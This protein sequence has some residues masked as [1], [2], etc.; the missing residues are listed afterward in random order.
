MYS[1]VPNSTY[2]IFKLLSAC[3]YEHHTQ[4]SVL[5]CVEVFYY[6]LCSQEI[7]KMSGTWKYV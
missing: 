4:F 1:V 7:L 6:L 3:S 2:L 5:I